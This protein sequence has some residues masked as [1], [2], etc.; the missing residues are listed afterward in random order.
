MPKRGKKSQKLRRSSSQLSA[1]SRSSDGSGGGSASARPEPEPEPEP[2]PPAAPAGDGGAGSPASP[3]P[4]GELSVTAEVNPEAFGDFLT[5]IGLEE[6][7]ELFVDAGYTDVKKLQELS[8]DHLE[9]LALD[10]ECDEQ[11]YAALKEGLDDYVDPAL[12]APSPTSLADKPKKAKKPQGPPPPLDAA[13][14]EKLK[15]LFIKWDPEANGSL[16]PDQL[17]TG[18]KKVAKKLG[19]EM[20]EKIVADADKDGDG[21]I[22]YDEFVEVMEVMLKASQP[23]PESEEEQE[24]DPNAPLKM[25]ELRQ[26]WK[27]KNWAK[28]K[29][30]AKVAA[31]DVAVKGRD[32]GKKAVFRA[33]GKDMVEVKQYDGA[34]NAT[35]C[36]IYV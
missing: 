12:A 1:A 32:Q 21:T 26:P 18:L 2:E 4:G 13:Q 17:R 28:I 3:A 11:Q 36:A 24:E 35:F 25:S 33:I 30:A 6:K 22:D 7:I 23:D 31:K 19:E 34:K 27:A 16:T 20:I 14:V 8:E 5:S 10:C 9:D 29:V 15:K